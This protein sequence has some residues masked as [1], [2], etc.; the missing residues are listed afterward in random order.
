MQGINHATG[1][2]VGFSV[3]PNTSAHMRRQKG[4]ETQSEIERS[5]SVSQQPRQQPNSSLLMFCITP[6]TLM[7]VYMH[8]HSQ[9]EYRRWSSTIKVLLSQ[10]IWTLVYL[11]VMIHFLWPFSI[12]SPYLSW[13]VSFYEKR[14][15]STNVLLDVTRKQLIVLCF[16]SPYT[17]SDLDALPILQ[18][19]SPSV[20]CRS[21][22]VHKVLQRL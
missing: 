3:Q 4:K 17:Y 9:S 15:H 22:E 6:K 5:I 10:S 12:I 1:S 16:R 20:L 19:S 14:S 11:K 13:D 7:H 18:N 21:G 2:I 8:T